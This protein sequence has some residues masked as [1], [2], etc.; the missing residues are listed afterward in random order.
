MQHSVVRGTAELT[1][2]NDNSTFTVP[3][4]IQYS[5]TSVKFHFP[6]TESELDYSRIAN[7]IHFRSTTKVIL[8]VRF[9]HTYSN[10]VSFT[11]YTLG[12]QPINWEEFQSGIQYFY[13]K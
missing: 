6:T 5:S 10:V 12:Q 7:A 1:Y 3:V 2:S 8:D 11:Y 9:K 13:S 4:E